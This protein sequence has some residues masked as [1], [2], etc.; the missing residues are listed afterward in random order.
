MRE[1]YKILLTKKDWDSKEISAINNTLMSAML[2]ELLF[3]DDNYFL[4]AT[5]VEDADK[6]NIELWR[7]EKDEYK[8]TRV[9]NT[10]YSKEQI[11]DVLHNLYQKENKINASSRKM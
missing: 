4:R 6:A 9:Y 11:L 8:I 3:L 7:D 10:E 2:S 1:L 5:D